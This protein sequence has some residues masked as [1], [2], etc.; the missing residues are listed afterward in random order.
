[1]STK[2]VLNKEA[3]L[4]KQELKVVEVDLGN[5]EVVYVRQMTGHERDEWEKS[6]RRET[7]NKEGVITSMEV[8]LDDFRAKLA[9]STL[10]DE[11]GTLLLSREDYKILSNNMTAERLETI[12]N[13]SQKINAI[14]KEDKEGLIKNLEAIPESNSNSDSVKS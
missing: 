9:V 6:M 4:R 12:I 14:T 10:C 2:L 1:M 5:E 11:A 3:L 7:R 13:Q 8:I